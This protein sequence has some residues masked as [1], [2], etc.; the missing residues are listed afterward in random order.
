M[1]VLRIAFVED[2]HVAGALIQSMLDIRSGGCTRVNVIMTRRHPE[3]LSAPL[4]VRLP[5]FLP[6][7]APA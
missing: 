3:A 6:G 7:L 2:R 4:I 5:F 1:S